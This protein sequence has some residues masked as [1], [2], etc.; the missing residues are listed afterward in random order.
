M[1]TLSH[2][3][4]GYLIAR[5][6]IHAGLIPPGFENHATTIAILAANAPDV[7]AF[8]LWRAYK[9]RVGSVFHAP[10]FWALIL[11]PYALWWH[12]HYDHIKYIY[13]LL[14]ITGIFSHFVMD[15]MDF[16]PGIAWFWP[17]S[18]RQ[19]RVWKKYLPVPTNIL[20]GIAMY[21]KNPTLI[22]EAVLSVATYFVMRGGR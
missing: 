4:A 11:I 5:S 13:A 20:T 2:T 3:A 21:R 9:H 18:K 6:F 16:S 15:T 14:S 10:L 19:F 8:A 1:T 17:L 22:L 7:D 12:I